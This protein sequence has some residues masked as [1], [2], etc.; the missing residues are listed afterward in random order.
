M[1]EQTGDLTIEFNGKV[2]EITVD[3][4]LAAL[5]LPTYEGPPDN[6]IN[7][8]IFKFIRKF[9]YNGETNKIRGLFETNLKKEWNFFFDCISRCFMKKITNFDVL[10]FASLKIRHDLIYSG[11]FDAI[12]FYNS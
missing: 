9:N 2:Y 11:N 4:I 10:P 1:N 8:T 6:L 3:D 12:L 5:K 7:E